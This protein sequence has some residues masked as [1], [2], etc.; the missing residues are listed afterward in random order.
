MAHA[1]NQIKI[2]DGN[3]LLYQR[4]DVESQI[5][6]IRIK[7]PTQKNYIRRSTGVIEFEKAKE[8]AFQIYG[9]ITQRDKQKLPSAERH[10]QRLRKVMPRMQKHD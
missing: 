8:K 6:Q 7:L 9:E 1:E 2:G 5:W 3:I 4:D 10:F